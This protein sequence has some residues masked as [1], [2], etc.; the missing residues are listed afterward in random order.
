MDTKGVIEFLTE[1]CSLLFKRET[2]ANDLKK[3]GIELR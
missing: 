1:S 3:L 2:I